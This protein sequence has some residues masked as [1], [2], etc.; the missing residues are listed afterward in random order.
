MFHGLR[1]TEP[2]APAPDRTG[3]G[4]WRRGL[5]VERRWVAAH[6]TSTEIG[7]A[8]TASAGGDELAESLLI[9]RRPGLP[10]GCWGT[11]A[12]ERAPDGPCDRR[13]RTLVLEAD[14]VR[15][16]AGLV[17]GTYPIHDDPAY[18]R[19]LGYP[20][21]LVQGLLLG[22]VMLFEF[23]RVDLRPDGRVVP[24]ARTR[25]NQARA[26]LGLRLRE[27]R[28][29]GPFESERAV[30]WPPSPESRGSEMSF[31]TIIVEADGP[32]TVLSLNRP[33]RRNSLNDR[34]ESELGTA[35]EGLARDPACRVVVLTG[36]G[37]AFCA[38]GDFGSAQQDA[39]PQ[40]P[41]GAEQRMLRN[42]EVANAI[43][44]LPKPV[45]A[46]VNGPAVGAG[47]NLALICD[48]VVAAEEAT[49]SERH[50][51]RGF[52]IDMGGTWVTAPARRA[53]QGQGTGP[54]R[55]PRPQRRRGRPPSAW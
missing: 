47:C 4:G 17:G 13:L 44:A 55:R 49:F 26:L 7:I 8:T 6:R 16:F 21:V 45:I 39:F 30:K 12:F 11:R 33:D 24:P 52:C 5:S 10:A 51:G 29:C 41:L 3:Y 36:V 20:D 31:E 38:G 35:F 14:D 34:M 53:A 25:R 37:S 19:A 54:D 43:V 46:A 18:A 48:L 50:V 32:V 15:H 9:A 40:T 42:A 28:A 22:L 2:A 27:N 1:W 23:A